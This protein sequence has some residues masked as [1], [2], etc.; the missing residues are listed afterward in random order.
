MGRKE[1]GK[2]DLKAIRETDDG[3]YCRYDTYMKLSDYN[4]LRRML[5]YSEVPLKKGEYL[6]HI[7]RR[8][9]S[10]TGDFSD[11]L[12]VE[13]EKEQLSFAGYY[14]ESFSQ[15][16][17]NGGD[18]VIVLPDENAGNLR[19]YYR[20][21]AV[22]LKGEAPAGLS[23]LLNQLAT[24]GKNYGHLDMEAGDDE[25]TE[26]KPVTNSCY[27]TDQIITYA[28]VNLVRD[29]LI[30]EVKYMLSSIVFP[31][32]YMGL[33]F[34]CV[35]LTVLSVQQLSDSSKYKF[36]YDV[37]RKIGLR[38]RNV[39]AVIGKQLFWYYLCPAV[40]AAG[41]AGIIAVF[42]SKNFIF[43]TGVPTPVFWYFGISFLLFF[44]IY[45]LYFATTYLS[46]RRNVEHH[47][48]SVTV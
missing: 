32:F 13:G 48:S 43:Y 25:E 26:E 44:G 40:F 39:G 33:V 8:V 6:I 30:P 42:I 28:A 47:G 35:A 9:L 4:H 41:I 45:G 2:A 10:E 3:S 5:G 38:N 12:T 36:R 46:F 14:T 22:D 31:C 11:K 29:N 15:D 21:L 24:D 20:E 16:G 7:K 19:P 17:H 23:D 18:Y 27:G 1:D 34:V 37:L